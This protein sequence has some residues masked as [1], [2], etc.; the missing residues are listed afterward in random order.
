MAG[1]YLHIPYCKQACSYCDFHFSTGLQ[2][3]GAMVEALITELK[4]RKDFFGD[5][6]VLQTIYLGGGTPS[7]LSSR[8]LEQLWEAIHLQFDIEE[9]AEITLEANPDDLTPEYLSFL[10]DLGINRLSIGIQSFLSEE[11]AWMNRSHTVG[12]ALQCIKD[13]QAVGFSALSIDLIF[14]TPYTDLDIWRQQLQ[15]AIE[16]KIPHLS[17][18]ALTIEEKTA[19]HHW[20]SKDTIHLPEDQVAKT[21]FLEAHKRLTS[22]GYDHY[23]LSN[24][25]LPGA[26]AQ[27]NSAYW[28]GIP[29]LGLGPSAHSFKGSHRF[30]NIAQNARYIQQL[31]KGILPIQLT[32]ELTPKDQYNEYVM[33]QLRTAKGISVSYVQQQFGKR[34]EE[35]FGR[36]LANWEALGL[37]EKKEDHWVLTPEGWWV[38]DG[39]IRELFD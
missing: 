35:E 39:I 2:S 38:S 3:K 26:Q 24:Y 21:Q 34:I 30:S 20:V 27:H 1:L 11:L 18:Y 31:K 6:V 5:P 14:G 16:L 17:V 8:E 7:L 12:Q 25:A 36:E 19:L 15:Q 22:V 9:E 4:L 32:E 10:K 37:M 13:A 29:Y 28:A 33:T 23:E